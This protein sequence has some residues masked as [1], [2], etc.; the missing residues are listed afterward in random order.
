MLHDLRSESPF[1]IGYN[2][3]GEPVR[4]ILD[5]ENGF[6]L[7]AVLPKAV[8]VEVRADIHPGPAERQ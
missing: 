8:V 4:N 2:R 3:F 7:A 1:I 5:V 6:D